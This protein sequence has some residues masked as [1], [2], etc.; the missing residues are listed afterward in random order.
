MLTDLNFI[1]FVQGWGQLVIS[2][3]DI[4]KQLV[5]GPDRA[6]LFEVKPDDPTP[7]VEFVTSNPPVDS[8]LESVRNQL[9]LLLSTNDLSPR[10]IATKLDVSSFPSGIALMIEQSELTHSI[11]D[12]QNLYTDIEPLLWE[13]LRRWH[14]LYYDKKALVKNLQEIDKFEDSNVK[15]K[16]HAVKPPISEKEQLENIEKRKELGIN[17]MVELLQLDDP[18]LSNDE[19]KRKAEEIMNEKKNRQSQMMGDVFRN[20]L[21]KEGA[22]N[23]SEK[24]GAG[25]TNGSDSRGQNQKEGHIPQG[26]E[27]ISK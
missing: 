3:R 5:G 21:N 10:T 22:I 14:T 17:T 23:A 15:V 20:A 12:T 25:K 7:N 6:F 16:F 11:E 26:S 4:P 24:Q 18:D 13:V 9:A 1:V 8:W 27:G 19:A 2:A